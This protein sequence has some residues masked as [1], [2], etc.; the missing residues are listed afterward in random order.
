MALQ[1]SEIRSRV[2]TEIQDYSGTVFSDSVINEFINDGLKDIA[3]RAQ[4]FKEITDETV[5]SDTDTY[6]IPANFVT[7]I[8]F[9]IDGNAV[10]K[11]TGTDKETNENSEV[12]YVEGNNIAFSFTIESG[13]SLN[14]HYFKFH[15]KLS[16]DSDELSR[17]MNGYEQTLVD[18]C[19][20]RCFR[21]DRRFDLARQYGASYAQ[22]LADM[23][24]YSNEQFISK[25]KF[26]YINSRKF[27]RTL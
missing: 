5:S 19:A 6:S 4:P 11:A 25:P 9:Y 22:K 23:R 15:D 17:E 20:W 13:S 18:Y 1:L 3:R 10:F 2:K 16:N 27:W 14:F 8:M 7:D 26:K 12:Y 24:A 21:V